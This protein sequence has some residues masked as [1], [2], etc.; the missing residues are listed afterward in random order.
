MSP[1]P[2]LSPLDGRKS[3]WQWPLDLTRYDRTPSLRSAEQK[4]L[5]TVMCRR[6]AGASHLYSNV[7]S[8][9]RLLSPIQDALRWT[10]APDAT[11]RAVV[12][13]LMQEMHHRRTSFWGWTHEEWMEIL[14]PRTPAFLQCYKVPKDSRFH[15]LALGYL[16]GTF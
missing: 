10:Q 3:G 1:Q 2:Q 16:T 14:G 6:D 11:G 13:I 15:L 4:E 7:R 12:S 9:H 5:D 8:L